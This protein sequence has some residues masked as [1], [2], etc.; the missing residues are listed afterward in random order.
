MPKA[1]GK[2]KK[3]LWSPTSRWESEASDGDEVDAAVALERRTKQRFDICS[4]SRGRGS[5][6][7]VQPH[8]R[9]K[10]PEMQRDSR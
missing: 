8:V 3:R 6:L 5:R 10:E 4:A 7:D 9:M 1:H 2:S